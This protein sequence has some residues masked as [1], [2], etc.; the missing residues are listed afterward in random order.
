MN[1]DYN[2]IDSILKFPRLLKQL[3]ALTCDFILCFV[4]VVCAFYLR[5]EELI[6]FTA[7]VLI[8]AWTSVFLALPIFWFTGLYKTIFRFSDTNI[9]AP[10]SFSIFIYGSIYFFIFA[11]YGVSDIRHSIGIYIPRSIGILQPLLLFFGVL[12]SRLLVK[13]IFDSQKIKNKKNLKIALIYGA[14]SAGRQLASALTNSFE[15]KVIGFLDND[16]KLHGKLSQGY[17]IYNP[18]MLKS[19]ISSHGVQFILLALPSI[20]SSKRKKIIEQLSEYKVTV[21]TLPSISEIV[22]GKITISNIK[23][24]NI[25]DILGR[26]IVPPKQNLINKNINSK[27]IL[28]TGAG[29][30]IGSQLCKFILKANPKSLI[31]CEISEF[32]LYKI[33]EEIKIQNPKLKII[34]L[35]CNI[36][37]EK[38]V[39]EILNT[40]NIDTV[41][42]SAAYKHVPL[43]ESNI[44][45]G[46]MNN[47]FGTFSV[48]KAAIESNVQN[49]VLISSDKAV[50]PTN[51]MG[52]SK[53]LA[54]MCVQALY[55]HHKQKKIFMSVVRFGNVL[56]SSGS[57]IPKFKQQIK[58]GGPVTLTHLDVTRYFMTIEEAAEL[59][60]QAGAMTENCEVFVLDM[61]QP[62]KIL[63]LVYRI[64]QLSGLTIK[65]ETNPDGDIKI[66][67]IGLRTGEKLYEELMLGDNPQPTSHE[68][69]MK[70]QDP[71]IPLIE[72]NKYLAELDLSLKNNDVIYIKKMLEKILG[73]YKSNPNIVDFIHL[74]QLSP[75]KN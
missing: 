8:T 40:F 32:A 72:L 14:G 43:V 29:G 54:E 35:I 52:A 23:E 73:T 63:D 60:I 7:P 39:S 66:D 58:S 5:I 11:I 37:D 69:I 38:K 34:P 42:H 53:R 36:Q 18:E 19:L 27:N 2:L 25:S 24:L 6:F 55:H 3:I 62:V 57:V 21:Q 17:K 45:E 44:C 48:T 26:E 28:V 46:I 50:R 13:K 22:D 4:C 49:F 41:Y 51:I 30:S 20:T 64:V 15:F 65:D 16:S 70:A 71:F 67:V 68:K 47:V 56:E 1:L 12:G 33:H 74:E 9:V 10:V 59:V 31:L 61:G 75:K